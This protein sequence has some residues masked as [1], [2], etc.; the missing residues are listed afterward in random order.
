MRKRV[1]GIKITRII[2][3]RATNDKIKIRTKVR[4][5]GRSGQVS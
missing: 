1:Q 4:S 5:S 2:V 3:I